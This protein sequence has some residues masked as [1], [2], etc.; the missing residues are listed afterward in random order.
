MQDDVQ[1]RSANTIRLDHY[2]FSG[3]DASLLGAIKSVTDYYQIPLTTSSIYGIT[4]L[5]FLHIL[6]EDLM[7]PNGGPPEPE[8]FKL[9]RNIGVNIE[10][11]HAYAEGDYFKSL[12]AEAWEKAK[13]AINAKQ[14]VFA[15]N[16]DIGNQTSVI[17]AYD[18]IGYYTDSWHTGY[19]HSED[20]IPWDLLGLSLCPCINCVNSRKAAEY[21][22]PTGGHISLHWAY[23]IQAAEDLSVIRDAL[24]F[25]IRLNEEGTYTW[26]G[27]MYFVGQSAYERWLRALANDD[28]HN[29][30]FSLFVEILNES[31]NHAVRFLTELKSKPLEINERLIDEGIQ[32]Y[33]EIS[34]KYKALRDMYPYEEPPVREIKEKERCVAIVSELMTL[35]RS[36]LTTIKEIHACLRQL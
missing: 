19:E 3:L 12:Q 15:K 29:Y 4:G 17:N 20:V 32:I 36:A 24:E 28:I 9:A 31:R 14:P 5:A 25:V 7:E 26:M 34:S 2:K 13:Q 30:Y 35:E 8:I 27:K 23:P 10:G 16:I 1:M 11:I 21:A 6:D 22:N 18:D 33:S